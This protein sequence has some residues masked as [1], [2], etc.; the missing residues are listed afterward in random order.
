MKEAVKQF[1]SDHPFMTFFL[2]L[3][4]FNTV[5]ILVRGYD[6]TWAST[7]ASASSATKTSGIAKVAGMLTGAPRVEFPAGSRLASVLEPGMA[8]WEAP[9][10]APAYTGASAIEHGAR[11]A[12]LYNDRP[13][14]ANWR[15]G[16]NW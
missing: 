6:P 4:A 2:G 16:A 13:G 14:A 7:A 5:R 15:G 12:Q 10:Y 9:G 1:A 8:N 11:R 3:A